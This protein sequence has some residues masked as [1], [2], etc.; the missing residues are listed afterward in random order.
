MGENR[1]HGLLERAPYAAIHETAAILT[2]MCGSADSPG[3]RLSALDTWL[4]HV[5]AA[6][7]Q[8]GA[9]ESRAD[10]S[11]LP[12]RATRNGHHSPLAALPSVPHRKA[13]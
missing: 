11:W 3:G 1:P 2:E 4:G 13:R 10:I 6:M 7:P 5:L 12:E 9:L 8:P